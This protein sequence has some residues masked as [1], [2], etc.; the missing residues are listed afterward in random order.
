MLLTLLATMSSTS[1]AQDLS[2][3][4]SMLNLTVYDSEGNPIPNAAVSLQMKKHAF[5]FGSQVRDRFYSISEYE[6]NTL[7]NTQ[8]QNLLPNLGEFGQTPYTPSWQDALNYRQAVVDNFNHVVPTTGMQWVA[9]NNSGP[10][11]PDAAIIQAQAS[12]LTATGA[13]VV[14]QR[15]RWP[16]PVEFRSAASPNANDFHTAMIADRLS[17]SGVMGRFSD[18][19]A[20][21]T[22]TDWKVLNEPLHETYYADTFVAAGIYSS[23]NA[24]QADYFIRANAVHPDA[25]LSINDFNIFNAA[26]DNPA[27][28]FR[29]MVNALLAAGAPIDRIGVQAH[30]SRTDVTKADMVRRINILAQTGLGIEISEFDTR[31]DAAQLT[32]AQQ[33]QMFQDVL[34]AAFESPAVDGFIMWGFWDPGHWRGNGPLFDANWNVKTEASPW[35]NLVMDQW[36][37]DITVLTDLNGQWVAPDGVFS[38]LY[39]ITVATTGSS[40]V[41]NDYDLSSDGNFI[42]V[43]NEPEN[44]PALNSFGLLILGLSMLS[45]AAARLDAR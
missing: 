3:R 19:G 23:V 43:I 15:D 4:K 2:H 1:A 25:T 37:T 24:A 16:T 7:T 31:D 20:G 17:A 32:S 33:Q 13:S 29:D 45:L 30:M 22:I 6:F 34:E 11:V 40:T 44:I 41:F 12:G 21:P 39:D 35:F 9:L 18:T 36:M 14:W 26:T 28:A 42:L 8:K 10:T 5:K 38:G 27:I